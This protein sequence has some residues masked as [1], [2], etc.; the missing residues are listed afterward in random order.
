MNIALPANSWRVAEDLRNRFNRVFYVGFS[1][2][3]CFELAGIT[4]RNR[5]E[6]C[7]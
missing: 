7:S 4:K 5:G 2:F 3:L 6:D 1:L